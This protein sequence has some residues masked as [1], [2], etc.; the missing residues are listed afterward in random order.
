MP[1]SSSSMK[2]KYSLTRSVIDHDARMASGRQDRR[3]QNQEQ[4]DAINAH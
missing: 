4:A 2:M 3:Q 1:V